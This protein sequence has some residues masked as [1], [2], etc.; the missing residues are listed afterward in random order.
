M[1]LELL[2][3]TLGAVVVVS[4]L[5]HLCNRTWL[6]AWRLRNKL[7]SQGVR[8]PAPSLL[9]GNLPEMQRIEAETRA[10]RDLGHGCDDPNPIAHDYTST[11]FPYFERWRKQY[12]PVYMYSTGFRQHLYVT[13]PEF[14]KDMNQCADLLGKPSY[15]TKRLSPMMG[16]SITRANGSL[17]AQQRKIVAPEFFADKVKGMVGPMVESA[18]TLLCSW[19][20]RIDAGGGES[21]EIEVTED[22]TVF[23][24]EVLSRTSFGSSYVKGKEIYSKLKSLQ[25][26][27]SHQNFL[28]TNNFFSFLPSRKKREI[29]SLEQEVGSLIWNT[30]E[31]RRRECLEKCSHKDLLQLI[32]E[33]SFSDEMLDSESSKR[34]VIDNCK[35]IYFAGHE[36]TA[37]T[38]SWCVMLLA[39]HPEWQSRIRE[40]VARVCGSRHPDADSLA[41]LRTVTIV[42][43]E[44]LR[45]YPTAVFVSREALQDVRI[46]NLQVPKNT[47]LWTLIPTLHRDPDVWGQDA[48]EFNPQRFVNG[49]SKACKYPQAYTFS[50]SP[51]YRHSPAFRMLVVPEHG[52]HIIIRKI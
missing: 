18:E 46:G 25:H 22:L 41:R 21:V 48:N 51:R 10:K 43:Q 29:S 35:N 49:I 24:A 36:S 16:N 44:V 31:D 47:C 2:G 26:A 15:L 50:L 17:W 14:V 1:E 38:A 45:L 32:L 40:E 8:G 33:G 52:V 39:Q 27:I 20:T 4:L 28:F 13:K 23:S 34:L 11:L 9:Y 12:G 19:E 5:F 30:V 37:L 6:K 7:L 42:I 3:R